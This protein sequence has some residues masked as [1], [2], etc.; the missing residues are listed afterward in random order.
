MKI[1]IDLKSALCGLFAGIAVMLCMGA[2]TP[3]NPPSNPVGKY[4]VVGTHGRDGGL[5]VLVDTQTGQVWGADADRN[6]R[7]QSE[8]WGAK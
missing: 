2:G 8:F 5:F 3:S 6:F 1:Q 7:D 4:Q